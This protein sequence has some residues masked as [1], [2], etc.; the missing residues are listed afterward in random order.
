MRVGLGAGRWLA[1]VFGVAAFAQTA[2]ASPDYTKKT[3]KK[4]GYCHD[5]GWTSG[6]LTAAGQYFLAHN[7]SFKGF[8]ERP[9]PTPAHVQDTA[10][11]ASAR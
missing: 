11:R 3:R 8:V 10:V 6:K 5:G 4:C 9:T 2:W 7:R 1:V